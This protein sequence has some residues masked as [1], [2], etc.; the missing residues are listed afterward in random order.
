LV[1]CWGDVQEVNTAL[2]T[3]LNPSSPSTCPPDTLKSSVPISQAGKKLP[4]PAVIAGATSVAVAVVLAGLALLVLWRRRRKRRAVAAGDPHDSLAPSSLVASGAPPSVLEPHTSANA[5]NIPREV[6]PEGG[7]PSSLSAAD[8]GEAQEAG[9]LGSGV[10]TG[11]VPGK[12]RLTDL[13]SPA[14]AE[15]T[16]SSTWSSAAK[17]SVQRSLTD[18]SPNER[19]VDSRL[20]SGSRQVR[21]VLA[22]TVMHCSEDGRKSTAELLMAQW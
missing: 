21:P 12:L 1:T 9:A 20:N 2:D 3:C 8:R 19:P 7:T 18:A 5:P 10:A 22:H 4:L 6:R 13:P 15:F 14:L 11:G 16:R 17:D